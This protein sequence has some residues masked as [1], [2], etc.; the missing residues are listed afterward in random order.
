MRT[1]SQTVG[2]FFEFALC[3]RPQHELPKGSV[4][5]TGQVFAGDSAPIVDAL[6]ELW[7]PDAGWGRC[8]TNGEGSFSFLVPENA[9]RFEL[10]VFARGLLKPG[11][12]RLY[13]GSGEGAEDPTMIARRSND[14]YRFDVHMQGER[15][16][17]FFRLE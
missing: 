2:P 16:T 17:A 8:A 1:P 10:M 12:T 13:L 3:G 6:L 11:L 14:G 15:A 4:R 5:V 7:C 9:R